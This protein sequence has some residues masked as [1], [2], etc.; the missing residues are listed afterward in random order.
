MIKSAKKP[1]WIK[2]AFFV[3]LT[4]LLT[5]V[6]GLAYWQ[7]NAYYPNSRA[8]STLSA[9]E[10]EGRVV[11]QKHSTKIVG[12]D[13]S[14]EGEG[15]EEVSYVN[16][17]ENTSANQTTESKLSSE[18]PAIDEAAGQVGVIFYPGGNVQAQS[19]IPLLKEFSMTGADAFLVEMPMRAAFLGIGLANDVIAE[20]PDIHNWY[21][22]GHSL[23]GSMASSFAADNPQSVEGLVMLG[24]YAYGNYDARRTLNIYG[25]FN[26]S[27]ESDIRSGETVVKINGGNH[28]WFGDYG[29]QKG[30]PEA[31]ISHEEQ[32]SIA[33][34]S[35]VA[36]HNKLTV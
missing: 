1:L 35:F 18:I 33:V 4:L 14:G 32:Q 26:D 22:V 16:A 10:N 27:H 24:A 21:I 7:A 11:Y 5:V 6:A 15:E 28:A 13:A 12:L 2:I 29:I 36:F 17:E 31:T 20:N 9:L 25:S 3:L 19:Y 34:Q 23:G 8:L 30:D